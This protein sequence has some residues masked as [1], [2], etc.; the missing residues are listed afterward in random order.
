M[1]TWLEAAVM[2]EELY[3]VETNMKEGYFVCPVCAEPIFEC[4]WRDHDDWEK[5][6][7]C[8]EFF[9]DFKENF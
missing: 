2:C 4:D 9:V 8:E 6:P 5:C 7:V 3:G 1:F